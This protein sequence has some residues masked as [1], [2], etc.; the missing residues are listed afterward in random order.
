MGRD[1]T[2]VS[3][4]QFEDD[5]IFFSKASPEHLQNLKLILLVFKQVSE[6]K[7]NLKKKSTLS[8]INTSQE[9]LSSLALILDCRVSKWHLSY[10]GLPLGRN[11]KS[12]G[13]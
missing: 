4:L 11:P 2:K 13:F 9:W 1:G 8:G 5:T 7:I 6:L 3:L 12:I 10:L